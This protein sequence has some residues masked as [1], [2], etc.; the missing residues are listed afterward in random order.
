MIVTKI[1]QYWGFNPMVKDELFLGRL[2]F[3]NSM[4][5]FK[6]DDYFLQNFAYELLG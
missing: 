2:L 6:F 3:S 4:I 1:Y 5:I